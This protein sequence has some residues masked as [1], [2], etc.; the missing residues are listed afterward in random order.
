M[1]IAKGG[2][3]LDSM[4]NDGTGYGI[5]GEVN[6]SGRWTLE[7]DMHFNKKC[8]GASPSGNEHRDSVQ[9]KL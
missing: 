9:V 4:W 8:M 3:N 5:H 7:V 2:A 1:N 6:K